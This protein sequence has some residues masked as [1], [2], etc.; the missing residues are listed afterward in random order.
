MKIIQERQ[1]MR[2]SFDSMRPLARDDLLKLLEAAR[3][4]PTAHNMQNFEMIVVDDRKLLESIGNIKNPISKIFIKENYEQLSF[5][6]EELLRKKVGI[7][8]TNFP[9]SWITPEARQK[10]TTGEKTIP[11]LGRFV[12]TG[13]VLLIMVYDPGKRAPASGGDF[14]G[15]MSLGCVMENIWLMA[16]SLGIGVHI[17]SNISNEPIQMEVKRILNIPEHLKIAISLRL[18]Y[19]VPGPTKY[20]RVRRDV[21]DF[22]H[23]NR[24]GNNDIE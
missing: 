9:P 15:V 11:T 2:S 19:P 22:T 16:R 13:P 23:H 6:K 4:S 20:L 1:S 17:I 8:G 21:K 3:W 10:G 14:L 5:S 24:F 18:G 12:Q 7:L